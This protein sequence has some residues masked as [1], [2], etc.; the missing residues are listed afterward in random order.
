LE[1]G[2]T[3]KKKV[4]AMVTAKMSR[5]VKIEGGMSRE[6]V[7]RVIDQHLDEITYCY[8][9]ALLT[10]P[11]ILGRIVFE[12]KILKDGSVGEIRIVASS[13]NSNQIHGCIKSAIK[14]WQFPK[15]V[16]TEVIV[17]Y[18]FVFDLVSF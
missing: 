5:T 16:G 11:S 8:E 12:W 1:R 7:K 14:S 13:V 17:S 3:G 2:S 6:M 15:P 18:P 9:T 4:Q 10:N